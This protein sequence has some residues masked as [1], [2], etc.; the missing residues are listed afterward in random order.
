MRYMLTLRRATAVFGCIACALTS[1]VEVVTTPTA[2]TTSS[3]NTSHA[4]TPRVATVVPPAVHSAGVPS[5]PPQ[6]G[7]DAGAV[8]EYFRQVFP[9]R[10]L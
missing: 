5:L 6:S 7:P 1:P 2:V 9:L 8:A 4:P 10:I 3:S